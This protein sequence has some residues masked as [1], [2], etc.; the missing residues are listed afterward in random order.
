MGWL[1][2]WVSGRRRRER[3]RALAVGEM[4]HLAIRRYVDDEVVPALAEW[5][6]AYRDH[7]A[8]AVT[9]GPEGLAYL[10]EGA[11]EGLEKFMDKW[12]IEAPFLIPHSWAAAREYGVQDSFLETLTL[13]I[14]MKRVETLARCDNHAKALALT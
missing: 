5:E 3:R 2:D 4:I 7:A 8:R 11:I 14:D 10:N 13:A 6:L 1:W 9:D 12:V